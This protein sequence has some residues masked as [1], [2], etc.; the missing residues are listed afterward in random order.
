MAR[1]GTSLHSTLPPRVF[2]SSRAPAALA[3]ITFV[4]FHPFART[5][6]ERV[7]RQSPYT[8]TSYEIFD[9]LDENT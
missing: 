4:I 7:F 8:E 6:Q 1:R 9:A 5:S 3:R 2:P